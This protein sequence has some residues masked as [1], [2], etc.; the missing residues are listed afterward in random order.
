MV[1]FL[2][3]IWILVPNYKNKMSKND[4]NEFNNIDFIEI[5][6]GKEKKLYLYDEETIIGF[7]W[8]HDLNNVGV[9]TEGKEANII[10]KFR[11]LE[12]KNYTLKFKIKSAM[13]N[14]IDKLNLHI[15]LDGKLVKKISFDRFSNEDNKFIDIKLKQENFIKELHKIDFMIDNPVSPLSLLESSDGRELG[16]LLE[17][18]EINHLN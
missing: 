8:T 5:F 14:N 6:P 16:I 13:T 15:K 9:W 11:N 3:I 12:R 4:R 18:V 2:E 1:S 17:S 10:F 7:G